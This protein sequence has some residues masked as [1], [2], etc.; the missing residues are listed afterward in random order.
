MELVKQAPS[1]PSATRLIETHVPKRAVRLPAPRAPRARYY[2]PHMVP[3]DGEFLGVQVR[4]VSVFAG[5][6]D[7][8]A[9]EVLVV[10]VLL[11]VHV[12]FHAGCCGGV[13]GEEGW[14]EALVVD[15]E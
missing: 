14:V 12:G 8:V 2:F 9:H 4:P 15:V 1:S 13:F 10:A 3:Q 6:V 7:A 5:R 11:H